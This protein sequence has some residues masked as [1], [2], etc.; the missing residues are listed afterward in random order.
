MTEL[1]ETR[2]EQ[3]GLEALSPFELKNRLIQRAGEHE[4]T[5]RHDRRQDDTMLSAG[6]GNPNWTAL[7]PREAF[8]LLGRFAIAEAREDWNEWPALGGMPRVDGIAERFELYL[9]Q[10]AGEPGADLLRRIMRTVPEAQADAVVHELVDGIIGDRHPAPDRMLPFC[11]RAVGEYVA[12]AMGGKAPKGGYDLFA[13]EGGTAAMCYVFDSLQANRVLRRG[14]RIALMTPIFTPYL[15][16]P[17]LERYGLDVTE[18]SASR[19]TENGFHTWAYDDSEIDKPADPSIRLLCLVDP[20]NPPSVRL[21]DRALERIA[22]IVENHN[23]DSVIVTDDVYGTFADGFTSLMEAAPHNT[24]GVSSFSEYFGATGWRLGVVGLHPDNTVDEQ[25]AR[26]GAEDARALEERHSS[27]AT[28]VPGLGFID[29]MVAD[30]RAVA[31]NHTAGLSTPQQVQM[32]LFRDVRHGLGRGRVPAPYQGDP[33]P[34]AGGAVRGAGSGSP[35]RPAARRLRRRA[36]PAA[37]DRPDVG[38]GLRALASGAVRAR[39]PGAAPGRGGRGGR[40]QRRRVRRARVV[41]PGVAGQPRPRRL[42]P[43]R[44][45]PAKHLRAGPPPLHR[46]RARVLTPPGGRRRA[47]APAAARW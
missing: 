7:P 26:L 2:A 37:L 46:R 17:R 19:G 9:D 10:N 42:R 25:I 45:R 4:R 27:I 21:S 34:A 29:R 22:G 23:R 41:G 11:E 39:G 13:T 43:H 31:L 36:G 1:G 28:D 24:I 38:R 5:A 35:G 14:D 20:S 6:R 15:E 33:V 32:A 44:P 16:I 12:R 3:R 30:S 47:P 18:V 40:A 8:F